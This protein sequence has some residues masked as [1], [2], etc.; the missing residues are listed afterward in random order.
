MQGIQKIKSFKFSKKDEFAIIHLYL[1]ASREKRESV[2]EYKAISRAKLNFLSLFLLD[3]LYFSYLYT[4]FVFGLI[5]FSKYM[6]MDV[7][8]YLVYI[9]FLLFNTIM[10]NYFIKIHALKYFS[11]KLFTLDANYM[12][13]TA[14]LA[15]LTSMITGSPL[16]ALATNAAK[17]Y[18]DYKNKK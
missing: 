15:G 10:R 9:F 13:N 3:S 1:Q 5:F 14:K 4:V 8:P 11:K 18:M 17:M 7:L 6:N 16:P 2:L 12:A